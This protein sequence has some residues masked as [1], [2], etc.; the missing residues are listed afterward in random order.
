[1]N[2][3]ISHL[4]IH[5]PFCRAKCRYCD[6]NSYAGMAHLIPEYVNALI[7]EMELRAAA[8]N[9]AR[10]ET[11]YFG[12]GTPSLLM[13]N[14][15]ARS[16]MTCQR[17]FGRAPD[18]E[19]T[20][21]A[22]PGTVTKEHLVGLHEAGI[23]RLSLGAQS[24][25]EAALK[26]LGRIHSAA[27]AQE[28]YGMAREAGFDNVNLDLIYGLPRQSLEEWDT[29]LTLALRLQPEHLSL[30]CLTIEEKTP[31]GQ[32]VARGEITPPDPDLAAE[33]YVLAE[34]RLEAAGYEHYEIS[35]WA[36]HG[37]R[38][39]HNVACW[40][41]E[42]YLGFGAGAHSY[43]GGFR[44]SNVLEPLEYI[45]RVAR[46]VEKGEGAC[47]GPA[48]DQVEPIGRDLEMAETMILGL[49]LVEGVDLKEFA[50]RFGVEVVDI[51]R[52][53]IEELEYQGLLQCSES[54]LSLTRRGRLLGNEV[55]SRFLPP[56]AQG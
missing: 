50:L 3:A 30:Y 27:Q 49:R 14:D 4:Y 11:I 46:G 38:C 23:N 15:V 8:C 7:R 10:V 31:L 44:Y 39:R 40:R 18:V 53:Q 52:A 45:K 12:G 28:A 1:M 25:N 19:I 2:K 33:M 34:E 55:F 48:V 51:Y 26:L 24:F 5:I 20:L 56:A 6:F 21:E 37:R 41:N 47:L 43:S 36:K 9:P 29:D 35:N 13:V 17:H 22:N 42:P 32:S 54:T 16:L